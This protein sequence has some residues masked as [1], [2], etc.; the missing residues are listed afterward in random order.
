MTWQYV[1]LK[2]WAR[3]LFPGCRFS[4]DHNQGSGNVISLSVRLDRIRVLLV[5]DEPLIALDCETILRQLGVGQI[6]CATNV[7]DAHA[8]IERESFD[9]AILDIA[10]GDSDSLQL[11]QRLA[12]LSIPIG[13]MS[14]Y[15]NEDLPEMLRGRPFVSKPFTSTQLGT[16]LEELLQPAGPNSAP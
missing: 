16:L 9:V 15:R 11:S 14:G 3:H 6:L 4:R 5:E 13:F 1:R 8:A 12:E 2:V 7:A 10:V